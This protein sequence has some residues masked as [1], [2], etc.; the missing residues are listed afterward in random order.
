LTFSDFHSM[1]E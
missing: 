1:P